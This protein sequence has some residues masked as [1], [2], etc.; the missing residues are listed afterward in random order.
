MAKEIKSIEDLFDATP[1]GDRTLECNLV[2]LTTPKSRPPRPEGNY[3][4][5]G[6][7]APNPDFDGYAADLFYL[8]GSK[9]EAR[10]QKED[11]VMTDVDC[12]G[13]TDSYLSNTV[14]STIAII[15]ETWARFVRRCARHKLRNNSK[16]QNCRKAPTR[17]TRKRLKR[18]H[19]K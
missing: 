1:I 18:K 9:S 2:T 6:L 7:E 17:Q 12:L 11:V 14:D 15:K 3:A 10:L 5:I 16:A 8:S 19:Y 4:I 13:A